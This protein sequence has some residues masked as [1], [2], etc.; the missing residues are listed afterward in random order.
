MKSP[1]RPRD[2]NQ[3]AKH[4]VDLATGM[5]QER[6]LPKESPAAELGRRGVRS[7]AKYGP[8]V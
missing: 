3:S 7:A 5:T 6:E 2:L 8:N 1:K 4:M